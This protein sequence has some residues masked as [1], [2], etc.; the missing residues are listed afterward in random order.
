MAFGRAADWSEPAG[1]R[2]TTLRWF[3]GALALLFTACALT[4]LL[5]NIMCL[6]YEFEFEH[7]AVLMAVMGI[8]GLERGLRTNQPD[9]GRHV[10][11][12]AC[13]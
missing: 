6:R 10:S 5:H 11:F 2:R 7:I 13:C 3:L 4:I 1:K 8:L 9:T 12:G